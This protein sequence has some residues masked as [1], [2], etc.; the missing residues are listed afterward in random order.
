MAH[1]DLADIIEANAEST[2]ITH[3]RAGP[4]TFC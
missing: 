2:V 3:Q 1:D 4:S